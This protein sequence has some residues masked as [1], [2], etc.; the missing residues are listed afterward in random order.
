MINLSKGQEREERAKLKQGLLLA[1]FGLIFCW[2]PFLGLLLAV[3]G[4]L[5]VFVRIT[6]RYKRRRTAYIA[7]ALSMLVICTGALMGEIYMYA[8]NPNIIGDTGMW[9]FSKLT[10]MDVLPGSGG[11]D[12]IG[13]T[14][15]GPESA[16]L[17]YDPDLFAGGDEKG[18]T[19]A[20]PESDVSVDGEAGDD[21]AG[22]DGDQGV[23]T[24]DPDKPKIIFGE[25]PPKMR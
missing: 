20:G 2:V 3:I 4:F 15:Y 19:E 17:G 9:I 18:E 8:D 21:M 16:G 10:G 6:K 14:H 5:K 23:G 7:L 25:P 13:G 12:Y 22:E 1:V 24:D 11:Q